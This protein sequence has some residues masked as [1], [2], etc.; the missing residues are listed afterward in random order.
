MEE[1]ITNFFLS[2]YKYITPIIN[3]IMLTNDLRILVKNL[4][5][6]S[7]YGKKKN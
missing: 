2:L 6:K 5:K 1:N 4:V 3:R 7:F